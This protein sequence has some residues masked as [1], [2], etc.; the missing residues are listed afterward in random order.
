MKKRNPKKN[1]VISWIVMGIGALLAVAGA[2]TA[3]EYRLNLWLL[4]GLLVI[5]SGIICHFV[6][7]RCPYC[8]HSLS[9]Y[10]PFPKECPKCHKKFG[11]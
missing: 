10:R 8:G 1:L 3:Q 4:I 6:T 7:V 11:D 5:I 9:G 2:V